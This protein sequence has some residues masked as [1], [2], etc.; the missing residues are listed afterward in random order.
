VGWLRR[1]RVLLP[2]VSVLARLVA[3]V[4]DG[5]AERMHRVLADAAGTT[6]SSKHAIVFP[7]GWPCWSRNVLRSVYAPTAQIDLSKLRADRV[8]AELI[9][10]GASPAQISATGVGSNFP[11]YVPDRDASGV[12]LAGPAAL[13]RSIRITLSRA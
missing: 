3:S 11:Q 2:G 7:A 13:N 4:R 1:N 10:L 9:A 6:G 8:R 12:L 5:A